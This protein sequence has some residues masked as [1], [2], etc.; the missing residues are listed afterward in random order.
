MEKIGARV[1]MSEAVPTHNGEVVESAWT[2]IAAALAAVALGGAI[3]FVVGFAPNRFLH[4]AA[5][6]V[7]HS[8]GFPCH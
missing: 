8:A 2:T 6:D 5:H 4:A 1:P 7:R 3:L